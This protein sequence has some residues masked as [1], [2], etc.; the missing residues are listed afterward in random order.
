[1]THTEK[2]RQ[3]TAIARYQLAWLDLLAAQRDIIAATDDPVLQKREQTLYESFVEFMRTQMD[4]YTI[5]DLQLDDVLLRFDDM[6]RQ[7]QEMADQ[8]QA[9]LVAVTSIHGAIVPETPER[10]A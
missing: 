2:T 9:I 1:M 8:V 4:Y 7:Q 5:K 6:A 3:Q 10:Q